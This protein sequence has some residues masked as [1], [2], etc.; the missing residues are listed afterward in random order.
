[1]ST[2]AY[3]RSWFNILMHTRSF[4]HRQC[5]SMIRLGVFVQTSSSSIR[6]GPNDVVMEGDD[7]IA[8]SILAVLQLLQ[9]RLASSAKNALRK[10]NTQP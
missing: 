4:G 1:M 5:S 6:A 8:R 2:S 9:Y 10:A 7:G 3:Q